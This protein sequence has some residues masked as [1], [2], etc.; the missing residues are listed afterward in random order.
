[1]L[2]S[3]FCRPLTFPAVLERRSNCACRATSAVVSENLRRS[4]RNSVAIAEVSRGRMSSPLERRMH[5]KCSFHPLEQGTRSDAVHAAA[6]RI[7][8]AR[9]KIALHGNNS[10][11]YVFA[12]CL[13]V[14]RRASLEPFQCSL[15][16]QERYC[17]GDV[18]LAHLRISLFTSR[19][20]ASL[21]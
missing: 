7:H 17:V 2:R 14:N 15:Q 12:T 20:A 13:P 5:G 18:E 21:L 1:M 3:F 6:T 16:K 10:R 8:R 11:S 4:T 19:L 9:T